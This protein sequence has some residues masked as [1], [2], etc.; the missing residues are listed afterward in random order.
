MA[1]HWVSGGR[2]R[3]QLEIFSVEYTWHSQASNVWSEIEFQ[4]GAFWKWCD[5]VVGR[6]IVSRICEC[7]RYFICNYLMTLGA[8]VRQRPV[9]V[10]DVPALQMWLTGVNFQKSCPSPRPCGTSERL[11]WE[12]VSKVAEEM[13]FGTSPTWVLFP[14][15]LLN[16]GTFL[17]FL[18]FSFL[19]L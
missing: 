5:M 2:Q 10:H 12:Q 3:G 7:F 16:L 19:Y 15:L 17:N 18:N 8:V 1:T 13:S 9:F 14:G 11:G 6:F 4:S